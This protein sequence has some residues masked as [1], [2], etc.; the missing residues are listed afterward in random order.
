MPSSAYALFLNVL[1]GFASIL[2]YIRILLGIENQ[3]LA[4][5][6]FLKTSVAKTLQN[7]IVI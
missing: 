6:A 5:Q 4:Y 3:I 2:V 7:V 1:T